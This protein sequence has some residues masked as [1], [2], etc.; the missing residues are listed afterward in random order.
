MIRSC[1]NDILNRN[2]YWQLSRLFNFMRIYS[3]VRPVHNM[4]GDKKQTLIVLASFENIVINFRSK[5]NRI[6]LISLKTANN[7]TRLRFELKNHTNKFTFSPS[8][9]LGATSKTVFMIVWLVYKQK[10]I[11]FFSKYL[12]D[13]VITKLTFIINPLLNE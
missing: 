5:T 6:K 13:P 11:F 3:F 10:N 2:F 4:Q 8:H 1:R 12:Y 9:F 7:E